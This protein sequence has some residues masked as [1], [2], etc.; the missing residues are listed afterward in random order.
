MFVAKQSLSM[1]LRICLPH[2]RDKSLLCLQGN[3]THHCQAAGGQS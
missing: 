2:H 3:V 1:L